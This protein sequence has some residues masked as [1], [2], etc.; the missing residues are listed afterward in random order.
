MGRNKYQNKQPTTAYVY[1]KYILNNRYTKKT[2]NTIY[3]VLI[4]YTNTKHI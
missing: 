3:K 2:G 1:F 4:I